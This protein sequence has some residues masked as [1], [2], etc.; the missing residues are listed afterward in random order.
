GRYCERRYARVN[1]WTVASWASSWDTFPNMSI[2][3]VLACHS[4]CKED[5]T[6]HLIALS[7]YFRPCAWRDCLLH[8]LASLPSPS[9]FSP[10]SLACGSRPTSGSVLL[11]SSSRFAL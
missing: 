1:R 11:P 8:L 2:R 10:A 5:G 9:H 6:S 7:G 4:G 3:R